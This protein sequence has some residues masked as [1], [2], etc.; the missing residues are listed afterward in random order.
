MLQRQEDVCCKQE[1]VG[2]CRDRK[3]YVADRKLYVAETGRCTDV[4]QTGSSVL[5]TDM[6]SAGCGFTCRIC[7]Q[8]GRDYSAG[9]LLTQTHGGYQTPSTGITTSS[10]LR[11]KV[12]ESDA[13]SVGGYSVDMYSL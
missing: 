12:P 13:R 10:F 2:G 8:A 1:Y 6:Q 5:D 7:Q 3:M 4:A 9:M 11:R